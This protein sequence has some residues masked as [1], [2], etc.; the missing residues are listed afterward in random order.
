MPIPPFVRNLNAPIV[1]EFERL[2]KQRKWD[3]LKDSKD[4]KLRDR[5][6]TER[7]EFVGKAVLEDFTRLYGKD[8]KDMGA[9]RRL[10]RDLGEKRSP[11]DPEDGRNVSG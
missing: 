6:W 11:R 3:T 7:S 8:T 1:K 2:A 4:K 10:L 9:W 5:Y